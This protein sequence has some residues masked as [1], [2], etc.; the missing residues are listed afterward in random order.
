MNVAVKCLRMTASDA[1]GPIWPFPYIATTSA[2][3]SLIGPSDFAFLIPAIP[4]VPGAGISTKARAV[5][6]FDDF[7]KIGRVFPTGIRVAAQTNN[8]RRPSLDLTKIDPLDVVIDDLGV[9]AIGKGGKYL[10]GASERAAEPPPIPVTDERLIIQH[11]VPPAV[12]IDILARY[13]AFFDCDRLAAA[14]V[15]GDRLLN[16]SRKVFGHRGPD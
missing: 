3:T 13:E 1:K 2:S 6:G 16:G 12:A 15:F 7:A 14:S 8:D 9:G 4:L 5:P 11:E 10:G